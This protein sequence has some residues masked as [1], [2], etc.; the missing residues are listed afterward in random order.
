MLSSGIQT[1]PIE[2]QHNSM[3]H[4][5]IYCNT[6]LHSLALLVIF[7]TILKFQCPNET[8]C[9]SVNFTRPSGSFRSMCL[10][11]SKFYQTPPP[12][13]GRPLWMTPNHN[14]RITWSPDSRFL[15]N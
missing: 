6:L 5:E 13:C 1:R 4:S 11:V 3:M 8:T 7:S 9:G 12:L 10:Q 14:P 15:I 2:Y